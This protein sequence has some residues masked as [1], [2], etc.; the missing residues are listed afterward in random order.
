MTLLRYDHITSLRYV[1][2]ETKMVF[3]QVVDVDNVR[4]RVTVKLIPRIDLQVLA[5]KLVSHIS[6]FSKSYLA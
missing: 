6:L 2:L 4:Q 3:L 5:S 1:S